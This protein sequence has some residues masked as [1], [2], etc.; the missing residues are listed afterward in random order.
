MSTSARVLTAVGAVSKPHGVRGELRL[1]SW[2]SSPSI[3]SGLARVWLGKDEAVA[4][5]YAVAAARPHQ[6][7]VLLTLKTVA[8]RDAAEKLRG[9]RVFA[10]LKDLPERED[11]DLYLREVEGLRVYL[12]LPEGEMDPAKRPFL[13]VVGGFLD[14]GG[15]VSQEI[16]SIVTADG[17]EILFPADPRFV[18][19]VDVQAGEAV[20]D[21]PPGLIELYLSAEPVE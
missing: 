1:R 16:W 17:K 13:G 20:I 7:A 21:P 9:L 10:D 5:E 2:A 14:A 6:D 18:L 15:P 8:D 19:D 4:K 12:P 11:G 3:F